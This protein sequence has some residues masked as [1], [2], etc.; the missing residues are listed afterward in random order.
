MTNKKIIALTEIHKYHKDMG[1]CRNDW[2]LCYA[3]ETAIKP[4]TE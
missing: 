1:L 4:V 2:E 3:T